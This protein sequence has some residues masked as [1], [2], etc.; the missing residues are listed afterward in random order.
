MSKRSSSRQMIADSRYDP[1]DPLAVSPQLD[2]TVDFATPRPL[3]SRNK[4]K[5]VNYRSL[6]ASATVVARLTS[7]LA[8]R[9]DV[10]L[11]LQPR[12]DD[13][14]DVR[15]GQPRLGNV[16]RDDDLALVIRGSVEDLT[17][18]DV[19]EVSVERGGEDLRDCVRVSAWRDKL[20]AHC[21][22]TLPRTDLVDAGWELLIALLQTLDQ[23][24]NFFLAC[25]GHR[26][27]SLSALAEWAACTSSNT[28]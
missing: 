10:L 16:G 12:V 15:D 26:H 23:T 11:L 6:P 21:F 7:S 13:V 8:Q 9:H 14:D 4:H 2:Y 27:R 18:L 5:T 24:V 19:G 1:H 3:C 28:D 17:L 22:S 25:D 20:A